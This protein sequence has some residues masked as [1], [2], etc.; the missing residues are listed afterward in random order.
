MTAWKSRDAAACIALS[1]LLLES[2]ET[3]FTQVRTASEFLTTIK[4]RYATPTTVSLGRLFL[5][6]LFPDLASFECTADLITH[7]RSLDSSYRAACTDAQLAPLPPSMAITIYFIATSLPDRLASVRDALLLKHP[8]ELTIEVLE[9]ALKD[10]E[11]NLRSVA[12]A[13]G[14][15]PPPLFHECTLLLRILRGLGVGVAGGAVRVRVE[16]AEAVG[17]TWRAAAAGVQALEERLVQRPVTPLLQL[18]EVTPRFVS[19]PQVPAAASLV[20]TAT[21]R[22]YGPALWGMSASQLV[23]LLGTPHAMYAVVDSSASD[24]V[25]SSVVS[26]GTSLGE[27]PVA[28][29]GTCVDTSPGA[30]PEDASPS[31]TLDSGASHRFFRDRTTLTPLPTPVSV[32][33]ADPTSGPVTARYTT[34]LPFPAVPSGSLT[35][36]HVPSFSRNLVG[37]RP[38]VSQHVGLWIEPSGETAVAAAAAAAAASATAPD[39]C[40]CPPLGSRVSP[41][42]RVSPGSCVWSGLPRVLP[43]F[44]PSLAPPCSPC[45]EGRLRA[46]PHSSS[47]R[48]ST[49]PFETL[50]LDVWGPASRP[51]PER[52][53]F[54]LVVVDDYS[55]YTTVSPLAKKSD[56]TS[57]LIRWLLTTADTCGRHVSCLHSDRGGEFRSSI[58]AGFCCE[59]G[60]RQS[61]TLP[62]SPQQNGVAERRI[63]LVMEIART[64][65]THARA[66]HFLWPYA[67]RYAAHQMNLWPRVA[68]PEDSS[69]Y[70]FYHPP[71]Q[72]FFDSRDVR[73]DESVP[74]LPPPGPAPSGVSHATPPPSVA[75]Q[76]QPPSPQS[77]SQPI[78]DPAGAS[79]C[80]EDPGGASSRGAGVG[81][82]SVIVR[83]PGSGGAG[84]GAEP[85]NTRDSSL[86]GAGVS[87]AGVSGAI[88]GSA[89]IG[90]APSAGPGE[91]GTDPVTSGGGATSPCSPCP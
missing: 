79:F 89:T 86:R 90:G 35:G 85:V 72:Q 12:S 83:G 46:T 22:T 39:P 63:G 56:I 40:H 80:G 47:L 18:V 74:Y 20:A 15:V 58:I 84:V 71:L 30:A 38:L 61:W 65:M 54:F 75:P 55:R 52:E 34:K 16:A 24:S 49:E 19:H 25:Y 27:L 37:V 68:R 76:V 48:L 44:P 64:S 45:V 28:S 78:A 51:G 7:R 42:C 50:H 53:S 82:E 66:P 60:I 87:G 36:F 13:S 21:H 8:S 1:S 17:V 29:V 41:S 33:Q 26:L 73:F 23:D 57:T 10:V 2:E 11:S 69:D 59:Q 3:H 4:A 62:E 6:F 67:V 91:P 77:S 88:P 43:S 14:V 31:F 81:A 9:S 70:T 5:P 32:A